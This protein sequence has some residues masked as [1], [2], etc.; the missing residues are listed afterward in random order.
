MSALV[1]VS[2][3]T[4]DAIVLWAAIWCAVIGLAAV[5]IGRVAWRA[6]DRWEQRNAADPDGDYQDGYTAGWNDA[7]NAWGT[8]EPV[9]PEVGG[10]V[11][12]STGRHAEVPPPVQAEQ[13]MVPGM[14]G[15]IPILSDKDAPS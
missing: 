8:D 14:S 12:E 6:L 7:C 2:A 5:L 9:S 4:I 11:D 3:A 13:T 1:S 10:D 15:S